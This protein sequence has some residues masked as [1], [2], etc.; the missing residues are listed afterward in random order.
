VPGGVVLVPTGL[1]SP[2]SPVGDMG[3]AES[4][5]MGLR[6]AASPAAALPPPPIVSLLLGVLSPPVPPQSLP[7]TAVL[8][9]PP[10]PAVHTRG[11]RV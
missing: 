2:P 4:W 1:L 3:M 8:L 6:P 10:G 7:L 5:R 9:V 11:H